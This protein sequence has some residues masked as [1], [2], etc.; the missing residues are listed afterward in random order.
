MKVKS[1][2]FVDGK[3]QAEFVIQM[4]HY[5]MAKSV[6]SAHVF[7]TH[8]NLSQGLERTGALMMLLV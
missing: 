4:E 2:V 1:V 5:P 3:T 8:A 6:A 7:L